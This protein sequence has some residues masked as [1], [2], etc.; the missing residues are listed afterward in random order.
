MTDRFYL[1]SGIKKFSW[2][3][4]ICCHLFSNN[5]ILLSDQA[6]KLISDTYPYEGVGMAVGGNERR[7]FNRALFDHKKKVSAIFDTTAFPKKTVVVQVVNISHGGVFFT[8]RA[9]REIHLQPNDLIVFKE[10]RQN[11]SPPFS[12]YVEAKIVWVLDEPAM[13]Y[14]GMGSKFTHLSPENKEKLSEFIKSCA[15][16]D[17]SS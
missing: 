3:S 12:I 5:L 13:E 17:L 9:T 1:F 16:V 14:I 6:E 2:N 7:Q 15:Q 11:D 8:I 10:F 4:K